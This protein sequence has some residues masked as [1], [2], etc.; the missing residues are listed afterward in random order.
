MHRHRALQVAPAMFA[1]LLSFVAAGC[2]GLIDRVSSRDFRMRDL[3]VDP[4]PV[5]VLRQSTDGDARAK[6]MRNLDEPAKNGGT[7]ELQTEMIGILAQS[8][9][10]D[11]R[12]LCR[13][14]A[15]DA[16]GRFDDARTGPHLLNAYQQASRFSTDIANPIRCEAM[17]ALGKKNTPEALALL[18]QVATTQRVNPQ[19]DIKRAGFEGEEELAKLLGQSDPDMQA[20]RD[21]RLAAIRALGASKNPKAVGVLVP[22]MDDKDVSVRDRAHEGLRML[23]GKSDVKP[24]REAWQRAVNGAAPSPTL[25]PPPT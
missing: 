6:A 9:T 4:D 1:A 2:S 7:A 17:T 25:A 14:A 3:F 24:D 10:G 5:A 18:T 12:P 13:L 19:P 20:A 21:T 11:P 8:A 15:I 22:L 16:L 23:T